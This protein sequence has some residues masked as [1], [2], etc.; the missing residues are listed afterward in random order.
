[1]SPEYTWEAVLRA[2]W[3]GPAKR[4]WF[5]RLTRHRDLP[6]QTSQRKDGTC[7]H[8]MR[9][10]S[11]SW[12]TYSYWPF[13]FNFYFQHHVRAG[14]RT[15]ARV[16]TVSVAPSQPSPSERATLF[17][18]EGPVP[19]LLTAVQPSGCLWHCVFHS[20]GDTALAEGPPLY[21]SRTLHLVGLGQAQEESR[22]WHV[23]SIILTRKTWWLDRRARLGC[24]VTWP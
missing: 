11:E 3:C 4:P 9:K 14:G 15:R 20:G 8:T 5:R 6:N 2:R 12:E 10:S 23:N 13:F 24:L 1:M 22:T 21:I 18:G 7:P 17:H 16:Y 19:L